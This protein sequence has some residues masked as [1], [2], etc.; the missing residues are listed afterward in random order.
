[1]L[2][3]LF[4]YLIKWQDILNTVHCPIRLIILNLASKYRISSVGLSKAGHDWKCCRF[5]SSLELHSMQAGVGI[6][7]KQCRCFPRQSWAVL[8]R[9][10]AT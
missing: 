6:I 2:K 3:Y 5:M 8:R 7:P 4:I 10:C 1:M 9:N